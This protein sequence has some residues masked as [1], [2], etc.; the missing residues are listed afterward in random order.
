MG[1]LCAHGSK[2]RVRRHLRHRTTSLAAG[3][4][5]TADTRR[6]GTRGPHVLTQIEIGA[7]TA[8]NDSLVW[9]YRRKEVTRG[10]KDE[11]LIMKRLFL[12]NES[13]TFC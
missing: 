6:P 5:R 2:L 1:M 13:L 10:N 4:A 9:R 12:P 11:Y 8:G 3:T 7:R